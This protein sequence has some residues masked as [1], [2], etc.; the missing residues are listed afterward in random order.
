M[1]DAI[2]TKKSFQNLTT[3]KHFLTDPVI[4]MYKPTDLRIL[5][6]LDVF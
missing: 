5:Q 3:V 1:L 6:L 2:V 4:N